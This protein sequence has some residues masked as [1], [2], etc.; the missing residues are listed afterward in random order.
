LSGQA[1]HLLEQR[2]ANA[3]PAIAGTDGHPT[4]LSAW[5]QPDRADRLARFGPGDPMPRVR[6]QAI[7]LVGRGTDC[8]STKT[9]CRI[10]RNAG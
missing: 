3:L 1:Q 5:E 7:P 6:V 4:D 10:S 2:R 8:S 9:S